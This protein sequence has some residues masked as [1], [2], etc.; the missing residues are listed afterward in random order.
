MLPL[1]SPSRPSNSHW[2]SYAA[3]ITCRGG[4]QKGLP[5]GTDA[6]SAYVRAFSRMPVP[7]LLM[8]DR[9]LVAA[10]IAADRLLG[11]IEQ[12]AAVLRLIRSLSA[13]PGDRAGLVQAGSAYF[14]MAS[15]LLS[16][17]TK[18]RLCLLFQTSRP[19]DSDP[20][21]RW[22]LSPPERQVAARL[23]FGLRNREIAAE[24]GLS[25]ETV[26]KH[27]AHILKKTGAPTRAA[28]VAKSVGP[29]AT[30]EVPASG[31][32]PELAGTVSRP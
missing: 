17:D 10:N 26:R 28:F 22:A 5:D 20:Y 21:V 19:D 2:G 29:R 18:L 12:P 30:I 16:T 27:V 14:R 8:D 13:G 25:V 4:G 23:E 15:T 32:T 31:R 11:A 1:N 6:P 3:C 7:A 9:R 24:F